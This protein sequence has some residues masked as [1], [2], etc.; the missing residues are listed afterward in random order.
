MGK[1][2]PICYS[3]NPEKS[4]F[5]STCGTKLLKVARPE[6]PGATLTKTFVTPQKELTIGTALAGK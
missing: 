5:C 2:C 1:D 4:Q 3:E 6:G